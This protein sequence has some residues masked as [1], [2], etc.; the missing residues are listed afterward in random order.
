WDHKGT[1][2]LKANPYFWKPPHIQIVNITIY[3]DATAAYKAYT[4]GT[5]DIGYP[6]ATA[7]AQAKSQKD[8]HQQG[9]LWINYLGL[10]WKTA[11]FDDVRA[12]QAFALA[13]NKDQVNT[14]AMHGAQMPTNHLIPQGMPGYNPRLVGPAG[15]AST[16]GD[17]AKAKTLW[18]Q[19]VADKCGGQA[20]NCAA[21]TLTYSSASATAANVAK[22]MQ[23]MWQTVLGVNVTLQSEDFDTL[24]GQLATQSVQ[25]WNVGWRAYYPDPQ[26]WLSL[27]FLCCPE[28][29]YNAGHVD[30]ADANTLMMQADTNL[31]A[32]QRLQQY[33]QAEQKL[34][35]QVAWIPY[36]QVTD[37]W[38][39]RAWLHGYSETALGEPSLDQWL[40]L[41]VT[42][43]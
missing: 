20:A 30:L 2:V 11:P 5:Q 34:V 24:L 1:L 33:Q 39:N 25:F 9:A 18:Q 32:A 12:R 15:V 8:Y 31:N 37:H 27:Q 14:G 43:H 41:Y 23:Q 36:D 10:N 26:D 16:Q 38:Q 21:V 6:P 19:Y 40:A 3:A 29:A 13:I 42:N 7:I 17:A 22:S 4:D 35:E 28:A